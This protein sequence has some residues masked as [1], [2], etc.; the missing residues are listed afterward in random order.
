MAFAAF[1]SFAE[2]AFSEAASPDALINITG[3]QLT[4]TRE[5]I[6]IVAGGSITI[7]TGPEIALDVNLGNITVGLASFLD[8]TG[9]QL[10]ISQGE[11]TISASANTGTLTGQQ[12]SIVSNTITIGQG[13]G[14]S[15]TG[16][17]L[18]T[19]SGTVT[20]TGNA[21]ITANGTSV[22]VTASTLKF[23]DPITGNVT[24]TWSNIH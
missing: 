1:T 23:W 5:N 11:E 7:E 18:T 3:Q 4:I 8:I 21:N 20:F 19:N 13:A 6:S 16:Q 14:A 17:E 9:Q 2:S 10:N 22:N 15:I 24:E 12:L